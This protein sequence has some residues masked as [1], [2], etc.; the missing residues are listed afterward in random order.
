M[1]MTPAQ[2]LLNSCNKFDDFDL[3]VLTCGMVAI[4]GK[5]AT[6]TKNR[7]VEAICIRFVR[8]MAET[9]GTPDLPPK[10]PTQ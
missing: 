4:A 3:Y 10:E 1:S 7:D 6:E 5:R 9:V 2:E 8:S